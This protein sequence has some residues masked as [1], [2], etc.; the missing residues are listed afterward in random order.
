M[1]G[2]TLPLLLLLCVNATS[3]AVMW[4]CA[5]LFVYA[6]GGHDYVAATAVCASAQAV[7]LTQHLWFYYRNRLRMRYEN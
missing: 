3:F 7:W 1:T 4:L 5:A 6:S 2:R